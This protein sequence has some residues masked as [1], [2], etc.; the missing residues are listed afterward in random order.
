MAGFL[1]PGDDGPFKERLA[2]VLPAGWSELS[3]RQKR[4]F[5]VNFRKNQYNWRAEEPGEF[6][7]SVLQDMGQAS[8]WLMSEPH[9]RGYWNMWRYSSSAAHERNCSSIQPELPP[10]TLR[11]EGRGRARSSTQPE[12][13]PRPLRDANL[14]EASGPASKSPQ[15]SEARKQHRH[16]RGVSNDDS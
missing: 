13:P 3:T 9:K 10:G 11:D 4:R 14:A 12:L 5:V 1:R 15:C 16:H 7:K 6:Q 2:S 8:W